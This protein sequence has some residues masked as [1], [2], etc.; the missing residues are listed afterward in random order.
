[1]TRIPLKINFPLDTD[2]GS[3]ARDLRMRVPNSVDYSIDSDAGASGYIAQQT[4]ISLGIPV[5]A[6]VGT[7]IRSLRRVTLGRPPEIS[8][9]IWQGG[10][11]KPLDQA[12]IR[13]GDIANIQAII[14]APKVEHF[15]LASFVLKQ[16]LS[17]SNQRAPVWLTNQPDRAGVELLSTKNTI[18]LYGTAQQRIYQIALDSLY[19]KQFKTRS[20]LHFE[21]QVDDTLGEVYSSAGTLTIIPDVY[22]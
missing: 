11:L 13:R 16:N 19:T 2:A 6:D 22:R 20:R 14:V 10:A 5:D 21:F 1:M 9:S 15:V 18:A 4:R 17:I 12:I 3:E 7:E 8:L